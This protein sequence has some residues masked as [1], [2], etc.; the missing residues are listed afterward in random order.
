MPGE[1]Q[2]ILTRFDNPAV[3]QSAAL[4]ALVR[5]AVFG[6]PEVRRRARWL[7]WEIGQRA[8]VRPASIHELY[9]ARGRGDVP[10]FTTPAINVRIVAY[11]SARAIFRAARRLDVGAVICE[12]ARSEIA[13]TDQRPDEYLTVMMAA[14]LREGF[15][16]PLFVQGDHVQVNAKKYAADPET[17]LA[18]I[19][20]LI[21]EEL[22]AGFYNIDVDTSTLVD[23]AQPTLDEQQRTNYERAAELTRFIRE[24]EPEGVTV[25]VGAEIGEVGGKNSDVHELAAFM[26][27]YQRTL[28]R[29]GAHYAGISKISVQ[30]GTSHGGVVLPDGSIAKVQL[31][32]AA[33]QALSHDARTKYGLG[34]AVQHGA[35]TLPP[36]AFGRFPE[37]EAVEIHLA[38]NFQTLVFDH[39]RL[40]ADLR[41]EITEWVTAEC[42][43]EWKKGDTEGQFIYK[44]RKKA[45]GPFKRRCWDL[46]EEVRAAIGAD[47][48]KTFAFLFEQ[49]R[50]AGTRAATDRYVRPVPQSH[51]APREALVA[52]PDDVEA[53]E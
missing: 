27:G 25:S 29:L 5:D 36:D 21:Q 14:A 53:G 48:E 19:R 47:L 40:P 12:I 44:S 8:E 6:A 3:R 20:A 1:L 23:L 38:T 39:P 2:T 13:Y 17:E 11:D 10:P 43:D 49:L 28:R 18:A 24:H 34:G 30:T 15:R 45:I 51:A 46:P 41:R 33:L 4:D 22:H 35:S 52:A 16:G 42:K 31:D 9:L 7:I 50:V 26:D 32:L 37:C